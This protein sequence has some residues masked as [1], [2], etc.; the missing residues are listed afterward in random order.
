MKPNPEPQNDDPLRR[1]LCQWSVDTPLPPRFQEQVWRRIERAET[2]PE[3]GLWAG[4]QAGLSR[5]VEGILPRPKVAFAYLS[6]FLAL[7][8]AAGAMAAQIKTSRLD[9]TLSMRYVQSIDPYRTD[10]PHP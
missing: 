1:V 6:V 10:S 2:G 5:L 4:L 7:G 9:S 3:L 8:V